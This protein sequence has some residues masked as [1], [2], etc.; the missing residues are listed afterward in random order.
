MKGKTD[1]LTAENRE[2]GFQFFVG[3]PHR[4]SK[5]LKNLKKLG[6]NQSYLNTLNTFLKN[7]KK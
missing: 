3:F 5:K 2:A 1:V 6:K 4:D 7:V